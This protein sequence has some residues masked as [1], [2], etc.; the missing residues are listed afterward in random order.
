ML[1]TLVSTIHEYPISNNFWGINVSFTIVIL[2]M[3]SLKSRHQNKSVYEPE[4]GI[5][6]IQLFFIALDIW[7]YV[8][9]HLRILS[10]TVSKSTD[11]CTALGTPNYFHLSAIDHWDDLR[12]C[13]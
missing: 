1:Y 9:M 5:Q 2:V 7:Q 8:Q 12:R 10:L 3:K 11:H 6:E 13:Y 4:A